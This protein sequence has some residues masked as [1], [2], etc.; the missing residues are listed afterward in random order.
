MRLLGHAVPGEILVSP[1][2]ARLVAGSFA[3]QERAL[4][5]G[6]RPSDRVTAHVVMG[7]RPW[8][9]FPGGAM[10]R[11]RT[12]FVG[13][14]HELTILHDLLMEVEDGGG[15]VVGIVGE[16]GMGKSHLLWE[17]Q[18]GLTA[19]RVTYLEGHGFAYGQVMPYL[20]VLEIVRQFC[21][22][23]EIDPRG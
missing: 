14:A 21:G 1:Q 16:P 11:A 6:A 4:R 17:F 13:R 12:P 19:R 20:P 10:G 18:W 23:T 9:S 5:F 8:P 2:V 22:L 3:L 7:P 15:Q